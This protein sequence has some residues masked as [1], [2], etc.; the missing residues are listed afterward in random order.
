MWLKNRQKK[1]GQELSARPWFSRRAANSHLPSNFRPLV[2][3][4]ELLTMYVYR[5]G[6][7]TA[8]WG[9]RLTVREAG[10]GASLK[11][12]TAYVILVRLA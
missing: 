6:P 12:E 8:R 3:A 7:G 11:V 10:R 4:A 5:P 1:M 9:P 2:G